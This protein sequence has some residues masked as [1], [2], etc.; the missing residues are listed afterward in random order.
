[1]LQQ[2]T[3]ASSKIPSVVIVGAG[4]AGTA[5]AITLARAGRS[6]TIID[7]AVFPRDKCC[8]DGLTT[9]C[10]RR[11]QALGLDPTQVASWHDVDDVYVGAPNG[12]VAHFPLPRQKGRFAA[13]A[14]RI[15]LD[16]ALVELARKNG[17]TV[18]ENQALIG[19]SQDSSGVTLEIDGKP[20]MRAD[21]VIGADGMWSTL[22]KHLSGPVVGGPTTPYLG[23]WHAYR[24]YFNN[25]HTSES[26]DLWVWF[27]KD[28]LPGYA[29]CFP[30]PDGTV[31][32]GFGIERTADVPTKSMKATWASLLERPHIRKVL[33]TGAV[34]EG[35]PKAWPIPCGVNHAT[36]T[37]G[38]ALFVG[39]AALAGDVLTGEGIGQALQT[40][41]AAARAILNGGDDVS[42]VVG[43]YESEARSELG[44]DHQMSALLTDW[45]HK[46]WVANAALRISGSTQW[47]STNFA[48][49]LFEDYPRGIALTPRRWQRGTL[50]GAGAWSVPHHSPGS[51]SANWS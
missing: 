15:D 37:K 29:W 13:V 14:R 7:K 18:L 1:M 17:V 43:A 48:R 51:K 45:L 12:R 6:V 32:F 39:D 9:G 50:N 11:L 49:W 19:A 23:E 26:R 5:A 30:L 40:G 33:G 27:E 47:T 44:P 41:M 31:N 20:D 34:P 3:E 28:L 42:K 25:V 38:R 24:Q 46:P 21:Y 10:L 16:F 35:S 2:K 36:L 8:G 22:R 4:P